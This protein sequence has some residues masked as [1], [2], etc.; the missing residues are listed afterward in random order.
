MT[1]LH[2]NSVPN[3]ARP[4]R[5]RSRYRRPSSRSPAPSPRR[6]RPGR[7]TAARTRRGVVRHIQRGVRVAIVRNPATRTGPL[8]DLQRLPAGP[9]P[10]ARTQL[11]AGEPAADLHHLPVAPFG[12]LLQ[13]SNQGGP[14]RIVHRLRQPGAGQPGHCKV[15]DVH[16]L[17]IADQSQR[18]F[19]M[20]IHQP[21]LPHP[22][23]QDR[24]PPDGPL[25][26]I[27]PARLAGKSTLRPGQCPRL[28]AQV[29][30]VLDHL[31]GGQR[32]QPCQAEVDPDI[33]PACR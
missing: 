27:R 8:P 6:V 10:A 26:V 15:F 14:S 33:V 16:R 5:T 12:F 25:T 1:T 17:V 21:S 28:P 7:P 20:R 11:R 23:M 4:H 18:Q 13:Q 2:D 30:R 22:A 31:A 29:P 3:R 9:Q 19:V 32:G 24:D